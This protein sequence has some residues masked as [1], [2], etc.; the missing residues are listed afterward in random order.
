MKQE[1]IELSHPILSHKLGQLRDIKTDSSKFRALMDQISTFLAYKAFD[2][3]E[4][5]TVTVDTPQGSSQE[6]IVLE[7]NHLLVSILR[8]GNG[9]INGF[10]EVLPMAKV[11]HIG[12]YREPS[13]YV[14]IEYY[15]KMPKNISNMDSFVLDPMLAT[16]HSA[17]AAISR[18]KEVCQAKISYICVLASPE[19][20]DYFQEHHPDV[21]IITAKIDKCLDDN[22]YIVPGL[23]DA[24]D[25]LYGTF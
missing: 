13:T 6:S 7:Q 20:L 8:A 18:L 11:G 16:G 10:L 1:V 24:G 15:F 23:G 21:K 19:G 5:E 22:K 2:Y 12:L 25:R 9:M 14:P 3:L 4:V 17:V